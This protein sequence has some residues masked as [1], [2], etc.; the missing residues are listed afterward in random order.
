MSVSK[1]EKKPEYKLIIIEGEE[2][3]KMHLKKLNCVF[4]A[5]LECINSEE[6]LENVMIDVR[7]FS[8]VKE[9]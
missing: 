4:F 8:E 3:K 1:E 6:D 2:L 9:T 5:N 7:N